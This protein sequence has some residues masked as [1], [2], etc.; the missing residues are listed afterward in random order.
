[1]LRIDGKPV[2]DSGKREAV[3]QPSRKGQP[4]GV[5]GE[6]AVEVRMTRQQKAVT[7]RPKKEKKTS[8]GAKGELSVKN[9]EDR[10]EALRCLEGY[11]E[12]RRRKPPKVRVEKSKTGKANVRFVDEDALLTAA[13]CAEA[14]GTADLDLHNLFT[15]QVV[16]TFDGCTSSKGWNQDTLQKFMNTALALL[17]GIQPRDEIEGMLASQMIGVHNL[18]MERMGRAMISD[19]TFRGRE[20]NINQATKLLRT[21]TGQMEALKRYRTG[22]Q[23]KVTVEHVHVNEGGQAIVGTINQ[24]G[25]GD[26]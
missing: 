12:K 17:H 9:E 5:S 19:Q 15:Q 24:G 6:L 25:G 13:K 7:N 10:N 2:W 8:A 22:G 16:Q 11:K 26:Q 18:A 3:N 1:V 21:F 20:A 4:T 14:T 23:Q